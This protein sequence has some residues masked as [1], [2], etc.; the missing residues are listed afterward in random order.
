MPKSLSHI[1]NRRLNNKQ[2]CLPAEGY[3]IHLVT[4]SP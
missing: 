4:D 3:T 1:K 2:K